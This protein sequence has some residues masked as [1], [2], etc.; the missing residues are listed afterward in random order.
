MEV[1]ALEKTCPVMS[2][3]K[4]IVNEVVCVGMPNKM[5]NIKVMGPS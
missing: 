5:N 2:E 1:S 3:N 4:M